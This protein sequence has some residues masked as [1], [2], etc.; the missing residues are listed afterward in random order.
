MY[1]LIFITFQNSTNSGTDST[2]IVTVKFL[3]NKY[4]KNFILVKQ[5]IKNKIYIKE[6]NN[7]I[8]LSL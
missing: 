3:F 8:N 4:I 2:K 6:Y 1:F 5:K 7:L